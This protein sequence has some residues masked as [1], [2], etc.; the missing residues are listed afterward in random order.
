MRVK[1]RLDWTEP[2]AVRYLVEQYGLS[3]KVGLIHPGMTFAEIEGMLG[4][5]QRRENSKWTWETIDGDYHV[6]F[7]ASFDDGR[8]KRFETG[9][10]SA[11]D[12]VK[13]TLS[14]V[15]ENL[16]H[17]EKGIASQ[18]LID[19]LLKLAEAESKRGWL[20]WT[21]WCG[22]STELI[23]KDEA[24]AIPL[25]EA[26]ARFSTGDANELRL[27][28]AAKWSGTR[29]WVLYWLNRFLVEKKTLSGDTSLSSKE[30][31]DFRFADVREL[32]GWLV[33]EDQEQ[34][35][36][37][38]RRYLAFDRSDFLI[39]LV[40]LSPDFGPPFNREIILTTIEIAEKEHDEE[41]ASAIL[42]SIP[43]NDFSDLPSV[44]KWVSTLPKGPADSE[45]E[46][47]RESALEALK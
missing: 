9:G 3:G 20:R 41:L 7:A 31:D 22:A 14:W 29:D 8:L 6:V 13:G 2:A 1:S 10:L 36:G 35:I 11:T 34:A 18:T 27:Y 40:K 25:S 33:E 5:P 26:A 32:L 4:L 24:A 46:S 23:R 16:A 28:T 15:E 43:R 44:K 12:P 19:S 38:A 17:P 37:L 30:E 42:Y 39:S 21:R 45:W 47:I